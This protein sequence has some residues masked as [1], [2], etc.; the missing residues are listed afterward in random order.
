MQRWW[1]FCFNLLCI[2]G[3]CYQ[4][5]NIISSYFRY[6]SIT[7]NKYY[8]PQ[9]LQYPD[10][11]YCFMYLEDLLNV[12][13][14]NQKYGLLMNQSKPD[15]LFSLLDFITVNDI[16]QNTPSGDLKDCK[17]RDITGNH[18]LRPREKSCSTFFKVQKYVFQQYVCY[19]V[20]AKKASSLRFQTV[21]KSLNLDRMI[22]E[23]KV[24][25]SLDHSRKILPT[26][27]NMRF[28]FIENSYASAYYKRSDE[29][30]AIK[31]SCQNLTM[32]WLGY[33]YDDFR[34]QSEG[35]KDFYQCRDDCVQTALL[36]R[37]DRLP[38][39]SYYNSSFDKLDKKLFSHSMV[40]NRSMSKLMG[41]IFHHCS[42]CCPIFACDYSYCLMLGNQDSSVALNGEAVSSSIRVESPGYP[43]VVITCVPQIPLLD[44]IIYVLSSLGTWFGLVIISCNPIK[45]FHMF[46]QR[47]NKRNLRDERRD[48]F[49]QRMM[50]QSRFYERYATLHPPSLVRRN[51]PSSNALV[52]MRNRIEVSE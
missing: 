52:P 50:A 49:L 13:A 39:T 14:I 9:I 17:Y 6:D 34:C 15:D 31:I 22:Y 30:I 51:R 43:Y 16:L 44:S 2:A 10:L 40:A 24:D 29:H 46:L 33:P 25:G 23:I 18:V 26:I 41:E 35:E 27:T 11:H 32:H 7:R 48:L 45:L 37:F 19:V 36:N 21:S 47:T 12:S 4:V 20:T 3:C 1:D 38:S 28:P 5:Q 8:Q 42:N